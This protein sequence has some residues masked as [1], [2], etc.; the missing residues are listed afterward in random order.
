MKKIIKIRHEK[1][2]A[3]ELSKKVTQTKLGGGAILAPP[4][5]QIG[6]KQTVSKSS[7]LKSK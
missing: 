6:L 2:I 7:A 5:V 1:E 4:P 3:Y